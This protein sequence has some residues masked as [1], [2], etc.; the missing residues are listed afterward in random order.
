METEQIPHDSRRFDI[1]IAMLSA[2]N[3]DVK[4]TRQPSLSEFKDN[5]HKFPQ[6]LSLFCIWLREMK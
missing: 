6:C 4:S 1:R 2:L 5:L 3:K